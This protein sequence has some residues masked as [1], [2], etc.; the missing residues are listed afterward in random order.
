MYRL[1]VVEDLL[2]DAIRS[3]QALMDAIAI[4]SPGGASPKNA[5]FRKKLKQIRNLL[6]SKP[7]KPLLTQVNEQVD[8][9]LG[10]YNKDLDANLTLHT[11]EAKQVMAIV[12]VMAESMADR[13]KQYNVRFRGIGKKLRVLTTSNDLGE[14]RRKLEAEVSQLEKYVDEMQRD[15][16]SAVSRVQ[17][18]MRPRREAIEKLQLSVVSSDDD[19]E[20]T[21]PQTPPMR[22]LGRR[23]A[24]Q[25]I[26]HRGRVDRRVCIV[27]FNVLNLKSIASQFGLPIAAG[28]FEQVAE[29]VRTVFPEVDT[30]YRWTDNDLLLLSECTLVDAAGKIA[31]VEPVLNQPWKA[32]ARQVQLTIRS[33]VIERVL[34]EST[35]EVFAR[36]DGMLSPVTQ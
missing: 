27:R 13:E 33:C 11:K 14:I 17:L 36:I 5:D 8:K 35:D 4:H 6:N 21:P 34:G 28:L 9:T 7:S 1:D 25:S 23:E 16:E 10:S 32:G 2:A 19:P 22:L 20:A 18:E 26:E 15:T 24:E 12:A 30:A 3:L 31:D 29:R